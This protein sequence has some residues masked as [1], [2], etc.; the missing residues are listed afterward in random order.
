MHS[1]HLLY[2]V[3]ATRILRGAPFPIN[4]LQREPAVTPNPQR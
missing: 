4:A 3:A 2:D 1:A